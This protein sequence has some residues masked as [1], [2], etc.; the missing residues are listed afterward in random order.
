MEQKQIVNLDIFIYMYMLFLK[1]F[2]YLMASAIFSSI[3]T[4]SLCEQVL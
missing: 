4:I 3:S 2:D 1:L